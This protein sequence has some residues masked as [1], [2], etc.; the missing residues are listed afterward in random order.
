MS[1]NVALVEENIERTFTPPAS[2]Q[3][4][5]VTVT[6]IGV[7]DQVASLAAGIEE[8]RG[9]VNAFSSHSPLQLAP[10]VEA[11]IERATQAHGTIVDVDAWAHRLA[12]DVSDLTD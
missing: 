2:T 6:L 8:L 12:K 1:G 4:S 11:L 3:S 7:T 9:I 5:P 10:E